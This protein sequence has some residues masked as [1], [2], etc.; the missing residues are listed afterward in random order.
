MLLFNEEGLISFPDIKNFNT[1]N[2][3]IQRCFGMFQRF[4]HIYFNTSNVTIQL[5]RIST[6]EDYL[7]F[8]Y[9]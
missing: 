8:Q 4:S 7:L 1:S 2:V 5:R 3:T 6:N 9:I